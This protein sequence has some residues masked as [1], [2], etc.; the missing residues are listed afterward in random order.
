[1]TSGHTY[2][3]QFWVNDGRNIGQSRT[4]TVTGGTNTSAPLNFGSDGTGPGQYIIGTFVA[5]SSGGQTLT[6]TPFSSGPNPNAQINLFQVRDISA[7]AGLAPRFTGIAMH[8]TTLSM[9]ATNGQPDAPFVLL[10]S[11][12]AQRQLS[13]WTPIL[14][15]SFD[16]NG[17]INLSTSVVIPTDRQEFFILR[18]QP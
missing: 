4:E 15:N 10:E 5:N 13:Q 8:G 9:Q 14:T 11:T 2:L 6:L 3:V 16:A 17:S 18:T 1:M 12:N 7:V